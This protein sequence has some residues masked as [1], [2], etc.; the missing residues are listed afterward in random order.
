[1][2]SIHQIM[3]EQQYT[4]KKII[5]EE[6]KTKPDKEELDIPIPLPQKIGRG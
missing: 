2:K 4:A 5:R 3:E 1:M 6:C